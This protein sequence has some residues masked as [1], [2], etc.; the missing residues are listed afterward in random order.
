VVRPKDFSNFA[1]PEDSDRKAI[2]MADRPMVV[3]LENDFGII[4]LGERFEGLCDVGRVAL[5]E[6]S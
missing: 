1:V 5:I 2:D 3:A 4:S 6:Q